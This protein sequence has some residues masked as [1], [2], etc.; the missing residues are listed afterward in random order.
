MLRHCR[1]RG[2]AVAL[3]LVIKHHP[4]AI[5]GLAKPAPFSLHQ[6][7]A[8]LTK[9]EMYFVAC[10]RSL[11]DFALTWDPVVIPKGFFNNLPGCVKRRSAS[12]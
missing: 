3:A 6:A 8:G 9:L 11:Y 4:K 1:G 2:D 12:C 7:I 10:Q 5:A